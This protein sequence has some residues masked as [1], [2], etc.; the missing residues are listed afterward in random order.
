MAT[1]AQGSTF[2]FA[3]VKFDVVGVSVQSPA[4]E[5]VDIT[6]P[7]AQLGTKWYAPTG[8]YT[9]AGRVSVDVLASFNPIGLQGTRESIA[10][11]TPLGGFEYYAI[12]ESVEFSARV[13]DLFR[14]TLNFSTT[15]Y[16]A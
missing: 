3:G 8:D 12:L 6:P 11:D 4:V 5:I 10:F 9:A 7:N 16:T 2:T 14:A 13:G 15:D 1:S